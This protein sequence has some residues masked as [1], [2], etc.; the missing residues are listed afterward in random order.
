MS[1]CIPTYN[2]AGY[3]TE[4][5]ESI[6]AQAGTV[7]ADA[8]EI[9]V[10]D[11]ASTDGTKAAVDRLSAEAKPAIR[12]FKN[13]RN[14]GFDANCLLAVERASGKFAWLFGSDDLLAP[15]ALKHILRQLQEQVLADIY[16]GEKEDFFLTPDRPMR[17]LRI[18]NLDEET[19]FDFR[20]KQTI[21][22]YFKHNRKLIAYCNFLSN[23]VF[24][25]EKW[26]AVKN[27][28]LFVGTQYIHVFVFQ[29]ILWGARPGLMKYLPVPIVKRR[30]GNDP[31]SVGPEQRLRVDVLMY[32][33]IAEAVFSNKRYVRLIDDLV[34]RND[35][36][37]WA[38]RAKLENAGR[39]IVVVMPFLFRRYWSHFL[40]WLKIV[41]LIF[42]PN[43]LLGHMRD[44]YRQRIKG[45]PLGIKN[46]V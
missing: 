15:G 11:N 35:G 3:L 23:L 41:P 19:I 9:I 8:F 36:F 16:F 31:K 30:W 25:R 5:I 14:V 2:R 4:A 6:L 7:P 28:E 40:F 18:M 34:I 43:I 24:N 27:K 42:V 38:V 20:R 32:R 45:E 1:I 17:F 21:D 46:R 12:Y 39:F 33:R 26:L 10:S 37:S 44:Q 13:D 29:T 22:D